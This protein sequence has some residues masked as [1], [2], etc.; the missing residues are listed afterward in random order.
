M[1]KIYGV[2]WKVKYQVSV[3]EQKQ[4]GMTVGHCPLYLTAT[5]VHSIWV[6][7]SLVRGNSQAYLNTAFF[8]CKSLVIRSI[9][10]T[11]NIN[12][13]AKVSVWFAWF[14]KIFMSIIISLGCLSHAEKGSKKP[15]ITLL[16]FS[17][18][19]LN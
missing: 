5:N 16:K 2:F 7:A 12:T 14:L 18:K 17:T 11:V 8:S 3:V 13:V 4:L 9:N 15:H 6:L 1:K 19:I 10:W